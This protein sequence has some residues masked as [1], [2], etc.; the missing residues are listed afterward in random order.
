MQKILAL[1]WVAWFLGPAQGPSS[2]CLPAFAPCP[3]DPPRLDQGC[4]VIYATDG[5]LMLGGNNEDYVN[6]L[7]RVWFIPGGTGSF[8]R[9]YLGFDDYFA[10]GGM[11]DQG[12]FFD[13]L[14]L[15]E[16]LPVLQEGKQHYV[17]NLVDRAMSECA[18]VDCVVDLFARYYT[19]D[20]WRWQFLFGDASGG[21]AIVEP[22]A[23]LRQEGRYQ[24]ATN[25]LQSTTPPEERTCWRY[26]A[27]VQRLEAAENLSVAFM[28]DLLDA[29]H[30]DGPTH[31][32]Y[33]NVYD[34][35]NKIVY[36]YYFHN[37]DDVVVLD[38]EDELA[39][40]YH[41]YDLPSLF[42]SNPAAEDWARP[43]LR[44]YDELI[45]SRLAT[46]LDPALLQAY[47]GE[48]D[49][50]EGWGPPD[51]PLIVVAQ[52]RSL[53]LRFPDYRQHELFP[54][55]A[56]GFFHVAFQGSDF[57]VAY[58]ATFGLDDERRVQHLELIFGAE[59]IR[60]D[61]ADAGAFV[62]EAPT[63]EPTPTP[64]VPAQPPPTAEPAATATPTATR[65][66]TASAE[67]AATPAPTATPGT[68]ALAAPSPTAVQAPLPPPGPE[69]STAF[70]WAA[71]LIVLL[72]L[73]GT[74]VAWVVVRK[75]P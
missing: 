48:Y 47:A 36:L 3:P 16:A 69:D 72:L 41:A 50:P 20:V 4:S 15:D 44:R 1:L 6:P 45:A 28:R 26:Q 13:G 43:R 38:L 17:G 24:V 12:L 42:P 62:P 19:Q 51:K 49:M 18:T 29:V 75:R 52:E 64:T 8:G 34:L 40:G 32:L 67:P 39:Q 11:N 31:T 53:L 5:R 37:Y 54:E 46:G 68:L 55:S 9:V 60:L 63:P 71:G 10:Q 22:Q 2:T 27:A 14:A 33:S 21:S 61:R 35:K 25:F 65:R 30:Q 66:P 70:P 59:S 58:Q 74:L 23:V 7:T 57:A 73:G 56:A